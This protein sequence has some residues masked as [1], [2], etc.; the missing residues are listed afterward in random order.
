MP[1]EFKAAL[2]SVH[3]KYARQILE[4]SKR[5]EFRRVWASRPVTHLVLYSTAPDMKV[6]AILKIKETI[7]ESK[8][9]LW[10][11]AK[12]YGG[13]LTREELRAYFLDKARGYGLIIGSVQALK[14]PIALSDAI[15]GMRAPQSYAYLT[16]EQFAVIQKAA[17]AGV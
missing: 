8:A 17:D 5:V 15:P 9:G 14:K 1:Q 4:G 7:E 11:L 16:D 13:G 3:P 6:V 12:R 10:E 2:I